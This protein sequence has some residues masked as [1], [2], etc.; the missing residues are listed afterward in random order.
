[1][2]DKLLKSQLQKKRATIKPT[3]SRKTNT[4]FQYLT[5]EKKQA[6][7]LLAGKAD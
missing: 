4:S 1:M 5:H 7:H 2:P 6:I 3:N